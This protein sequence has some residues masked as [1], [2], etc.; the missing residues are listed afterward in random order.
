MLTLEGPSGSHTPLGTASLDPYGAFAARFTLDRRQELGYY[1]VHAKAPNGEELYGSLRV[2]EFRPPNF[3]THLGLDREFAF[4]GTTVTANVASAYLFGAPLA[5]ARAHLSVTRS[6]TWFT[7]PGF[8][9]FSFGREWLYPEE[10]PSVTSDVLDADATLDAA[11]KLVR[12][13]TIE[14]D[15]P[16][17]LAY[18]VD[19][20]ATDVANLAVDD[21]ASLT[22]LPSETAI[23]LALPFVA[24]ANVAFPVEVVASDPQGKAQAGRRVKLTLSE[25][26]YER[27]TQVIEGGE[28]PADAVH[29]REVQQAE[30]TTGAAPRN[31]QLIAPAAGEYRVRANFAD[32]PDETSATD[33]ALWVSGSGAAGWGPQDAMTLPLKLDKETYRP[34]E[35]ATALIESPFPEADLYLAVVRHDVMWKQIGTVKGNSPR[36]RFRVTP[37]M[38][39]NAALQ[40]VLVRR[41]APLGRGAPAEIGKLAR[42]GFVPFKVALD[43]KYLELRI[44]PQARELFPGAEQT[45]RLS[46]RDRAG[47]PVQGEVALAVVNDA[48]LQ[49]SGYRFPDL[50]ALVY[51]QA[52]ISTRF[53]DNRALVELNPAKHPEEKGFGFGGGVEAGPAGTRLRTDFRALA[54]YDGAVRTDARG[55]ALVRFRLPDDLTT[56]R[57]LALAFTSDARF[58][59]SDATFIAAKPLVTNPIMPQFAR[60]GDRFSAGV[61]VTNLAHAAGSVSI[62]GALA[63]G[64]AFLRDGKSVSSATLQAP[65]EGLTQGYRF[66]VRVDGVQAARVTFRTKLGANGDAFEIPLPV[67]TSDLLESVVQ[68]GATRTRAQIPFTVA[69]DARTD[70]GGLDVTL[71]STLLPYASEAIRAALEGE[72]P[73]GTEVAG[74]VA[75]AADAL[76]FGE[77]LGPANDRAA[78]RGALA[79]N[80]AALRALALADGGFAQWPGATRSE[81]FSTAFA[82]R[83]LARAKAAGASVDAEIARVSGYLRK[84]L[85]DPCEG[86]KRCPEAERTPVR[87]EALEALGALGDVRSSYLDDIVAA[88]AQLS[89]FQNVELARHMLALPAYRK[90]ALALRDELLERVHETGRLATLD[91][92]G[93]ALGTRIAGQAQLVMLLAESG[94]PIA[95]VDR[96]FAALL[97]SQTNGTWPCTTDAAEALGALGAYAALE[98]V[99]PDFTA[100]VRAAGKEERRAFHGFGPAAEAIAFAAAALPR[101]RSTVE[102]SKTGEGTLRYSVAYRYAPAGPQAGRYQ[103]IRID[104]IVRPAGANEAVLSFGLAAPGQAPSLPPGA[105]FDIEDRIIT[106]HPL[107]NVAIGDPLPAG[108]EA[109][110]TSFRTSTTAF[111]PQLDTFDIS[112]RQIYRDRVLAFAQHLEAGVYGLH[113]L[114]RSQTEG[115]FAWPGAEVHAQYAPEEFGRTAAAVLTIAA[116]R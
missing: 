101:G 26:V 104:R 80:L 108:L 77:R 37:E 70:L 74:R 64:L 98:K 94:A 18:R 63:G 85:A 54:F 1:T 78:L 88:R 32:A 90:A 92:P 23:G 41:G 73:L 9:R 31:V 14:G 8:E 100:L 34:G 55:E 6:R 53:A 49:L 97:A 43:D 82:A 30:V 75:V 110:D 106:D 13:F 3:K 105:V 111:E 66:E 86:R 68:T 27:A 79:R 102:L 39:P 71:A 29:Y 21:T 103:G 69:Q 112:Y 91:V 109:I 60:P 16:Y 93:D 10:P 115:V 24:E 22:V 81:L 47:K 52:P 65:I 20:Q 12:P 67:R 57:V 38:L 44:A 5:N 84:R 58:G 95:E 45:V 40:A 25:R 33:R 59:R 7:P 72:S 2:A 48:V 116:P 11:G 83:A 62:V 4:K 96:A 76:A 61:S 89:Y 35:T 51:G 99:P 36:A 15:V 113:Y 87:F 56:W 28:T 19:A 46:V 17:A 42:I 107:D 114:V 50:V